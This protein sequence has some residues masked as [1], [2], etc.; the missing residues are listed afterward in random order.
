MLYLAARYT[1]SSETINVRIVDGLSPN[2]GRV[3][4]QFR[5]YWGTICD[6]NWDNIDAKVVCKQLGYS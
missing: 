5:G 2:V 4:V 1:G 6:D 3:E